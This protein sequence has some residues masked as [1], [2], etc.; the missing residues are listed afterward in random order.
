M[1]QLQRI[2]SVEQLKVLGDP[3]KLAI[4]RLLMQKPMTLSQLGRELEVHPAQI[5]HHL[6]QLEEIGL[7]QLVNTRVVRG[8]VEKYY[9]ASAR[10]YMLNLAILPQ[11]ASDRSI[12]VFGSH[13]LALELLVQ[14]IG[15]VDPATQLYSLPIGSLDGLIA[16]KQG[17]CNIAAC[18]LLDEVSGEYNRDY[19]RHLFP[20]QS[21]T[22]FTLAYRQQ[23]FLTRPGNPK[24]IQGLHDLAREDVAF[25]NRQRGSGTRL[26][27]DHQLNKMAIPD[28]QIRGYDL[29]SNTHTQVG[30]EVAEGRADAGI[31]LQAV[32]KQF[33][34]N[35]IPLF[36]E[37]FDLVL[38]SRK[39]SEKEMQPLLNH[40]Q[41]AV[42]RTAVAN[43]GGY[44]TDHTGE[45]RQVEG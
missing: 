22:L 9:Q 1:D 15:Q 37:R 29:E 16:L 27:L 39:T 7:L 8:F 13:D 12:M 4:L 2:K 3:K 23:G 21:M 19:V 25:A 31:A 43:L 30:R 32:A 6:K 17:L 18:H 20:G 5:R 24:G 11:S 36:V 42:L 33:E 26:W 40:L 44:D 28:K 38:P 35:F 14:E 10:A 41:S 34:L 45:A